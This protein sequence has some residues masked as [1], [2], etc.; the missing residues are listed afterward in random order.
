M[1]RSPW[2]RTGFSFQPFESVADL[3]AIPGYELQEELGRGAMG[4][5]LKALHIKLGRVVAL[6]MIL[7]GNHASASEKQRF[8][9]EAQSAARL[10]HRAIVPI[11]EV[12]EYQGHH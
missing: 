10:D 5:V 4:I 11:Y 1:R 6:K 3:P 9:T 12:G 7:S 8:L 2:T